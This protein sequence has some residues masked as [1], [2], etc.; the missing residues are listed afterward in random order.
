MKTPTAN[1]S[2]SRRNRALVWLVAVLMLLSFG[3]VMT[4]SESAWAQD[5]GAASASLEAR[6]RFGELRDRLTSLR[7]KRAEMESRYDK[8]TAV[9]ARKKRGGADGKLIG[10]IQLEGML[11][12]ARELADQLNGLQEQIREVETWLEYSRQEILAAYQQDILSLEREILA[13]KNAEGRTRAIKAINQLKQD[14]HLYVSRPSATPDLDLKALP[15]LDEVSGDPE[16]MAALAAELDDTERKLRSHINELDGRIERLEREKRIRQKALDFADEES[17]FDENIRTLR[18]ARANSK[19]VDAPN[20][21]SEGGRGTNT[22]TNASGGDDS[23]VAVGTDEGGGQDRGA[24]DDG[25]GAPAPTDDQGDFDNDGAEADPSDGLNDTN[26]EA[27]E[28]TAG[29]VDGNYVDDA[30]QPG[31]GA[32]TNLPGGDLPSDPFATPGVVVRTDVEPDNIGESGSGAETDTLEGRMRK[33]KSEKN[34]LERKA[35]ELERRSR[36][37]KARANEL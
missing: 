26:S 10:G 28:P 24:T 7:D 16:E 14:R 34:Q 32:P 6:A 20:A 18:I 36:E 30:P 31:S 29:G 22:P 15:S 23:N 37:L 12:Q 13:A 2:Q 1:R 4:V 8:L 17:F 11:S 35:R 5:K 33:L 25:F 27:N 21:P 19:V 3:G 9:I